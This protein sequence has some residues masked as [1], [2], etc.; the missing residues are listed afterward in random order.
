MCLSTLRGGDGG[1]GT[2]PPKYLKV[3]HWNIEGIISDVYGNKLDDPDFLNVI[4]NDDL[5]ALSETHYGL[6]KELEMAG[7][8]I[9]KKARPKSK[10]GK[11]IFWRC[12]SC[13]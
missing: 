4:K 10:K 3:T 11:K 1:G 2:V 13:Y 12:C 9:K 7:Y 8:V 6:T 5:I